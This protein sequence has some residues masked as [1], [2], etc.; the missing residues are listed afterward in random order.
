[1]LQFSPRQCRLALEFLEWSK[2]QLAA[3]S[4][5]ALAAIELYCRGQRRLEPND[6][7]AIGG[8]FYGAGVIATPADESH[9]GGVAWYWPIPRSARRAPDTSEETNGVRPAVEADPIEAANIAQGL[10]ETVR[11]LGEFVGLPPHARMTIG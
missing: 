1:M 8:A 11:I 3:Q 4:G 10:Q 9:H 6:L 7:L 5:V 2:E